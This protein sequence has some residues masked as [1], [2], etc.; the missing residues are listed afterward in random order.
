[1]NTKISRSQLIWYEILLTSWLPSEFWEM[2]A[3]FVFYFKSDLVPFKGSHL[4]RNT[5]W[6]SRENVVKN[7][8]IRRFGSLRT[9]CP[10]PGKAL[11]WNAGNI[12]RF[13]IWTLSNLYLCY[14]Y[15][16]VI[17]CA[18]SRAIL[19]CKDLWCISCGKRC[20]KAK[21]WI[22][23]DTPAVFCIRRIFCQIWNVNVGF[24]NG[25]IF[26]N[27]LTFGFGFRV[28]NMSLLGMGRLWR[29]GNSGRRGG[30][31]TFLGDICI[32]PLNFE[33]R[34]SW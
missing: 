34:Y 33:L 8:G 4:V 17:S 27:L 2:I 10:A 26:E 3:L 30:I 31:R 7:Y 11:W 5:A 20:P 29:V 14:I 21:K 28:K 32:R 18:P 16:L 6:F 22:L 15:K 23:R 19:C 1:M 9:S 24:T 25:G 12:F 13:R